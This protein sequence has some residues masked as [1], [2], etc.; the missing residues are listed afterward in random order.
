MLDAINDLTVF[1]F[2]L[3]V[4]AVALTVIQLTTLSAH[5]IRGRAASFAPGFIAAVLWVVFFSVTR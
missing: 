1:Q 3:L 2:A 4:L 5:V